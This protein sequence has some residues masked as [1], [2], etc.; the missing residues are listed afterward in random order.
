MELYFRA[1]ERG[2]HEADHSIGCAYLKGEGLPLDPNK[3]IYFFERAAIGGYTKSR[4]ALGLVEDGIGNKD[5]ALKHHMIA[6][7][8]GYTDCLIE[9]QKL[10]KNGHATKED[11]KNAENYY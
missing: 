5:R 9:I 4:G 10:Y 1:G 7:G 6:A 3:A 2:N 11:L 8:F